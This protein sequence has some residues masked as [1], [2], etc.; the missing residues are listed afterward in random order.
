MFRT[1]ASSF[2]FATLLGFATPTFAQDMS[3]A[4]LQALLKNGLTLELGGPGEGYQGKLRLE[5]DG[6]GAGSAVSDSGETF[7]IT[8][9]WTIEGDEFCRQWEFEDNKKV[10]ETWRR[11][12]LSEAEVLVDGEK[13]GVNAW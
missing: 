6:T 12:G 11:T 5:A 3:G 1:F 13:I 8:G 2:A 7:D 9:T 4:D 10:C